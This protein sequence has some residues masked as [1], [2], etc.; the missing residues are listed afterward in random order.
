MQSNEHQN[1]NKETTSTNS[2]HLTKILIMGKKWEQKLQW[3]SDW[4][5]NTNLYAAFR[6]PSAQTMPDKSNLLRQS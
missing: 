3:T 6:I 5:V 1:L 4:K 2:V